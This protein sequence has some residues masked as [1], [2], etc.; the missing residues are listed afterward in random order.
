[1]SN[2]KLCVK[3]LQAVSPTSLEGPQF[4]KGAHR[5]TKSMKNLKDLYI[6]NQGSTLYGDL[7][8][9]REQLPVYQHKS[10][11]VDALEKHSVVLIAGETG[12]GKSTQIPHFILEVWF[13]HK[14]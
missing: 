12:S 10:S 5:K 4:S 13:Y 14:F 7:L 8:K 9:T 3:K 6:K 1:M 11:I 2:S